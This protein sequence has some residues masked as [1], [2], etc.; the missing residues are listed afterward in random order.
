MAKA[1]Y[2]GATSKPVT[3]VNIAPTISGANGWSAGTE[4][5]SIKKYGSASL[6]LTGT[7]STVE[8][9][10]HHETQVPLIQSHIYY[11]SYWYYASAAVG[12][13]NAYWPIAEPAWT[14]VAIST[15]NTWTRYGY[16]RS[17]SSFTDSSYELR[18]DFNNSNN[19]GNLYIDGLMVIDL[20]A[21]FGSGNE[22]DATWCNSNIPYFIGATT[23]SQTVSSPVARK[24]KQPYVGVSSVA[25]RV[26]NGYVGVSGVA[27]KFFD[28]GTLASELT[29]GTSVFINVDGVPTEFIIVHQGN[30]DST[31]YD[32][33]CDGI[34][35]MMKDLYTSMAW[36]T[37]NHND[38]SSCDVHSYLNSTFLTLLDSSILNAISTVKIPYNTAMGTTENIQHLETRVFL[39]S[40][41]ETGFTDSTN[42]PTDG[43]ILDYFE[44]DNV[45]NDLRI[46]YLDGTATNWHLRSG[47]VAEW[48]TTSHEWSHYRVTT[49]GGKG[50]AFYDLVCGVRPAFIVPSDTPLL[51]E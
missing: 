20:T 46:A 50:T 8:I 7:T 2:I 6:C 14:S 31:L 12:S 19:A 16:V 38:Y 1:A 26:S 43:A 39:L 33:S 10:A 9:Y 37:T 48:N 35:L 36:D 40:A 45:S 22:P 11:F 24:V 34:W 29:V 17:Q 3:V 27:R 23:V 47:A 18:V 30:P 5:T 44:Y 13:T 15:A 25:R 51:T 21:C 42:E 4:S 28:G 32:S 49:T 41:I